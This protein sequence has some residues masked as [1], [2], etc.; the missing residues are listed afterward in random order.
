MKGHD[1]RLRLQLDRE[2][3]EG[4]APDRFDEGHATAPLRRDEIS[5]SLEAVNPIPAEIVGQRRHRH[6]AHRSV[7]AW[8]ES[9]R[10]HR[11][12]RQR[13]SGFVEDAAFDRQRQRQRD[14][15]AAH[16]SAARDRDRLT[17]IVAAYRPVARRQIPPGVAARHDDDVIDTG[18]DRRDPESP[19]C[20]RGNAGFG[21]VGGHPEVGRVEDGRRG[22]QDNEGAPERR[23]GCRRVDAPG[24]RRVAGGRGAV[25]LRNGVARRRLEQ[26]DDECEEERPQDGASLTRLAAA[27]FPSARAAGF[28]LAEHRDP[29]AAPAPSA[30]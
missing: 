4:A 13:L 9:R 1:E 20:V 14:V 16:V 25:A 7:A 3:V 10:E 30:P 29:S 11:H 26:R 6:H 24:H 22:N 8:R 18:D 12:A 15:D 28:R 27:R 17:G 2:R 5:A 19:G 21:G 23:A